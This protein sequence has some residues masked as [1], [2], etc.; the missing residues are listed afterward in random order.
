VSEAVHRVVGQPAEDGDVV[1]ESCPEG[2]PQV[3][4]WTHF[5][6]CISN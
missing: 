5:G 6:V 2:C 3:C 1:S 4:T